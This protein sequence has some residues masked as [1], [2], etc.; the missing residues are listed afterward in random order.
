MFAS[1]KVKV[2]MDENSSMLYSKQWKG[3]Q[4]IK[5]LIQQTSEYLLLISVCVQKV[6]HPDVQSLSSIWEVVFTKTT[7]TYTAFSVCQVLF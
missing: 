5:E 6:D 4:S 2:L 3:H 1:L 7:N